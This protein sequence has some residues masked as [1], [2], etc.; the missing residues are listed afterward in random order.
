[1]CLRPPEA[2]HQPAFQPQCIVLTAFQPPGE[3]R[4]EAKAAVA[5]EK[6]AANVNEWL[7]QNEPRWKALGAIMV[8]SVQRLGQEACLLHSRA[9]HCYSNKWLSNS[10]EQT[11][12]LKEFS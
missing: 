9:K 4:H 12:S 5:T 10:V 2:A 3:A 6:G 8:T 11:A 1:M 7:W